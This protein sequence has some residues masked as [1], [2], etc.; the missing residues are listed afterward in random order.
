MSGSCEARESRRIETQVEKTCQELQK[1]HVYNVAEQHEL[2]NKLSR[3]E[4]AYREE[5]SQGEHIVQHTKE[6]AEAR[7]GFAVRDLRDQRERVISNLRTAGKVDN[8]VPRIAC[9]RKD[10][11]VVELEQ[12][13]S[14]AEQSEAYAMSIANRL[15]AELEGARSK[16]ASNLAG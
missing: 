3:A 13:L 10:F 1:Q 11:R 6:Q 5:A 7:H 4:S 9:P 8:P 12:L 16:L 14:V 2:R 15:N